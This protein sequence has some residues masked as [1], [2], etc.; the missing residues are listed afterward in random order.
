[1]LK[2][3]KGAHGEMGAPC[4]KKMASYIYETHMHT[5]QG[6]ACG[7]SKGREY[8]ARYMDAGYAGII[9]TDHF[10]RGNCAIDRRLPWAERVHLFCQGFEDAREEGDKRNFPVFFG[11]EENQQGDEYLIY[12][13]DEKWMIAHPEMEH[14][15]R[16]EQ[17]EQVHAA[18]GCVVQ[19]H[20]FRQRSYLRDIHLSPYCVD[21]VEV[22]NCGNPDEENAL[23]V[24]YA[25]RLQLPMTGG[26]DNHCVDTMVSERLSG[27]VFDHPLNSIH[28][29]VDAIL[30]KKPFGVHASEERLHWPEGF[31]LHLPVEIRDRNDAAMEGD[32][33]RFLETGR[34]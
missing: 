31:K 29:Y 4:R 16:K 6:S 26:S 21:A 33:M 25:Q 27:V 23:A 28:D 12:G 2:S 11:L 3:E 1:M 17:Y 24:R 7:A 34:W 13:L 5:S 8:I 19:A 30:Q 14:W 32:V 20:P 18:G 9:V 22:V 10:F 15:T